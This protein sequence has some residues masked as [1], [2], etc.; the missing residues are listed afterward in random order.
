MSKKRRR[1]NLGLEAFLLEQGASFKALTRLEK[2]AVQQ[3][4]REIYA[5]PVHRKTGEW[6]YGGFDWHA[7]SWEFT[8]ALQDDAAREAYL[9]IGVIPFKNYYVIRENNHARGY[10]CQFTKIVD[11]H[12][13]CDDVHVFPKTMEWTMAFTHEE[14]WGIGPFFCAREWVK[15]T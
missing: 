7:F 15:K 14:G 8:K 4:W 3:Q 5:A 6:I 13:L 9:K 10:L 11:L 2:E 1:I 12:S